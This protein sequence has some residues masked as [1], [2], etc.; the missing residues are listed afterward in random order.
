MSDFQYTVPLTWSAASQSSTSE[1]IRAEAFESQL[2]AT[3]RIRNRCRTLQRGF[4][5]GAVGYSADSKSQ[6]LAL[7]GIVLFFFVFSRK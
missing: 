6:L 3:A 7:A 2:K 5:V 1:S 4:T